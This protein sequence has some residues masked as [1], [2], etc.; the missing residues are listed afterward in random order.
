M[1]FPMSPSALGAAC[2][3]P[4]WVQVLRGGMILGELG[5]SR[6]HGEL[7]PCSKS[8]KLQISF[9]RRP[10]KGPGRGDHLRERCGVWYGEWKQS[11]D[12]KPGPMEQEEEMPHKRAR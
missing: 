7:G 4:A 1:N 3:M 9:D 11:C 6:T 8:Y 10:G 12:I 5:G 2:C